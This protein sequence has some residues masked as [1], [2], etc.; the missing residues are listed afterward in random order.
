MNAVPALDEPAL[1]EHVTA[2]RWYGSK[3]REPTHARVLDVAPLAA[4]LALALVE[5]RFAEGTHETYQLLVGHDGEP[6]LDALRDPAVACELVRLVVAGKPREAAEGTVEFHP[7]AGFAAEPASTRPI[8]SEQTHSS[9]VLD[10]RLILKCYR[11]L[12]A[13][14]N[15]EL[16]M[17]RF[18]TERGFPNVPALWGWYAYVGR[19]ME[20]TLGIV[21]P[22]V[23]GGLDGWDLALDEL[24]EA[25][26]RFLGRLR[27]LGRVTGTMHT[28][29]GSETAEGFAPQEPSVET[30]GLLTATVDEE[31]ERAFARLPEHEA[32][33]P[34]AGR[35]DE[36]RE[37]LRLLTH[38]GGL[39]K[40]IRC[41]GDFH[42]GQMLLAGDD[43]IVID[44]EG[45]PARPLHDRRRKRSPLRDV[46]GMLRSFAYAASASEIARGV[47]PP[48]DWEERARAEF[49]DGYLE[50]VAPELIPV[51]R[52]AFDRLLSV[53]ELEKAV[54]ELRYELSTRPDWVA[55]PVAGIVRL[56]DRPV[57]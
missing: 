20:A 13:G 49:L 30:V 5:I 31:I 41:H 33:A 46:A 8:A 50:S 35:G 45:E 32:L 40:V 24:A 19:P 2:Q 22:F 38:A 36:V 39:G 48:P 14:V 18:L 52:V 55:I 47:P 11:R 53:F 57:S 28:L 42:L 16:E 21:Q 9:V 12:E 3:E 44:F 4:R 10:E 26:E 23:A 15:P 43:W 1:I 29:L 54:Y 25:P 27:G 7:L 51:G 37:R 56:L 6:E 17:L 34:V